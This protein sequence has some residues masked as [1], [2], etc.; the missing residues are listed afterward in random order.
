MSEQRTLLNALPS[1]RKMAVKKH[2]EQCEMKG[3]GILSILKSVGKVLGPVAKEFGPTILKELVIP[4]V[5]HKAG[6]K[7]K[8]AKGSG[9]NLSGSGVNLSGSGAK[10]KVGRPKN[11]GRPKKK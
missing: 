4:F 3:E 6:L 5:K 9:V 7:G 2:C 10:K 8:G 1:S 11:V